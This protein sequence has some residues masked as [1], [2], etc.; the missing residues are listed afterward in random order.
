MVRNLFS[1]ECQEIGA[2]I[3]KYDLRPE[4]WPEHA[5]QDPP[6]KGLSDA[7]TPGI[8]LQHAHGKSLI[9]RRL[10]HVHND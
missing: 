8:L 6:T 3:M 5:S 7:R 2:P 10:G 1:L 4:Q 9:P